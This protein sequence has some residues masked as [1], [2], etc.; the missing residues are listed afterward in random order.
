[1]AE[2]IQMDEFVDANFSLLSDTDE[3]YEPNVIQAASVED[4]AQVQGIINEALVKEREENEDESE[5]FAGPLKKS[6]H[7]TAS[8]EKLDQY[9]IEEHAPNTRF[10]TTWA[11]NTFK[12]KSNKSQSN[13]IC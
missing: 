10:Q 4:M 5:A 12:G 2:D 13:F 8:A 1:M 11:V 9:A 6:R 7:V 3:L